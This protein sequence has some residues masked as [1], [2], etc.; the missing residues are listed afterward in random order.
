LAGFVIFRLSGRFTTREPSV[1]VSGTEKTPPVTWN[2]DWKFTVD[3][4]FAVVKDSD[5]SVI[6]T[7]VLP[8]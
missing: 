4:G 5:L 2:P 6:S 1:A 8:T 7:P 3:S